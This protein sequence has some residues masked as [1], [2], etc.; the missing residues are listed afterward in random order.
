[1]IAEVLTPP[2]QTIFRDHEKHPDRRR[3]KESRRLDQKVSR[4]NDSSRLPADFPG[5]RKPPSPWFRLC[6][7]SLSPRTS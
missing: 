3:R 1:M 7:E 5:S 4:E 2:G 6:P